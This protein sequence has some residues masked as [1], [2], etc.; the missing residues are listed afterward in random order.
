MFA[1]ALRGLSVVFTLTASAAALSHSQT[2]TMT[3]PRTTANRILAA[4]T[5]QGELP[6]AKR[7]EMQVISYFNDEAIDII[8]EDLGR[9]KAWLIRKKL[10]DPSL[11]ELFLDESGP[12]TEDDKADMQRFYGMYMV[13]RS[14]QAGTKKGYE[15]L[16][17]NPLHVLSATSAYIDHMEV[18]K[19]MLEPELKRTLQKTFDKTLK[20][21]NLLMTE[22]HYMMERQMD[23]GCMI[24]VPTS[25]PPSSLTA[26]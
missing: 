20:K 11:M 1:P 13:E 24:P 14:Y 25:P 23:S 4:F 3:V 15:Y 18:L 19:T 7:C 21:L 6:R 8:N 9:M 22:T 16:K 10:H 5:P 17:R 12:R 26:Q 2:N